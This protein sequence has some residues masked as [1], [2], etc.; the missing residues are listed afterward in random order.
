MKLISLREFV[1]RLVNHGEVLL[2][3]NLPQLNDS[4]AI[5][6]ASFLGHIFDQEQQNFPNNQVEFDAEKA[7]WATKL[8]LQASFYL[9]NR[10]DDFETLK[11]QLELKN[12]I[13]NPSQQLSADIIL[14]YLPSVINEL[15]LFD[16]N[17]PLIELLES[18]LKLSTYSSILYFDDFDQ[19]KIKALST[20]ENLKILAIERIVENKKW[21]WLKGN[22]LGKLV[23]EHAGIYAS[24]LIGINN[25]E[26]IIN[27]SN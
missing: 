15:S 16:A 24:E 12:Q 17:D 11:Q 18:Q 13:L 27:G 20:D 8:L 4:D 9:L 1:E 25:L 23:K 26:E 14:K 3:Q 5:E 21:K 22:L 7:L 19:S 10:K 6:T 2:E